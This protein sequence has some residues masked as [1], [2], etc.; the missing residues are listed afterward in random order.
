VALDLASD[1]PGT[2]R[3]IRD[4]DTSGRTHTQVLLPLRARSPTSRA[5]TPF[6]QKQ[7]SGG[8]DIG[9]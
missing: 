7:I 8:A 2:G 3:K 1:L 9:F 6:G 5:P 4:F